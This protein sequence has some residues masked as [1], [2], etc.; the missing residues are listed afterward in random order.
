MTYFRWEWKTVAFSFLMINRILGTYKGVHLDESCTSNYASLRRALSFIGAVL[1]GAPGRG[2]QFQ[3]LDR[4]GPPQLRQGV[5]VGF[6]ILHPFFWWNVEALSNLKN[7]FRFP[8]LTCSSVPEHY[9]GAWLESPECRGW[10]LGTMSLHG[11]QRLN[12]AFETNCIWS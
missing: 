4:R 2:N 8:V 10:I 3:P 1:V 9:S 7:Y 5:G 11:G 6:S 12:Q